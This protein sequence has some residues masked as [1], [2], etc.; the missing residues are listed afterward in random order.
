MSS[1]LN[2]LWEQKILFLVPML[3]EFQTS[4]K[5]ILVMAEILF[6]SVERTA[7]KLNLMVGLI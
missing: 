1:L 5:F 3:V 2:Q 6:Y 7:Q 4:E